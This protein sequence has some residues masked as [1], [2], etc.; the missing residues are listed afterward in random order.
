[1]C[2]VTLAPLGL[3]RMTTRFT[4]LGALKCFTVIF[5][6]ACSISRLRVVQLFVAKAE[7]QIVKL[8]MARA[9]TQIV[10]LFMARAETQIVRLFVAK[11]RHIAGT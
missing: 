6:L 1:M 7:T 9:E 2:W 11:A 10:Q 3:L 5:R 4:E 8:F